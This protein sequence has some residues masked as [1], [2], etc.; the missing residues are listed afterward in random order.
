MKIE[1][2]CE[3]QE[4]ASVSKKTYEMPLIDEGDEMTFTREIWKEFCADDWCFGCTNCQCR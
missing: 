4:T 1:K 3:M 2:S